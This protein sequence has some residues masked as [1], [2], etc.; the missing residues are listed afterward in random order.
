MTLADRLLIIFAGL[1]LS[2]ITF[3][4]TGA[5]FLTILFGL[6]CWI[7]YRISPSED[8]KFILSV[9]IA[10]FLLRLAIAAGMHATSYL[11]GYGG[12][13][14]GDDLL[15]TVRSWA[16][17]FQW[18]GEPYS[19]VQHLTGISEH[20]VNPF[21]FLLALFYKIFGFHP[22]AVKLISCM[23][24]AFIGWI[25]Y[26]LASELFNR[27]AGRIAM[28]AVA[29]YPSLI[30][31]SIANLKDS[32][33]IL[34]FMTC[35][36]ICIIVL[37]GRTAVWKYA[38]IALSLTILYYFP[39][40][41]HF[42]LAVAGVGLAVFLRLFGYIKTRSR[43]FI[44]FIVIV[45]FLAGSW[46]LLFVNTKPLIK[47][48]HTCEAKQYFIAK[49]DFAGYYFYP[50][51]FLES[52]NEEKVPLGSLLKIAFMNTSYFM[53][54]PFP[55]QFTSRERA[56]AIP[57]MILW[58]IALFLAIFGFYRLACDKAR[59]AVL[60]AAI[61]II[62]VLVHAMAEGN[63]GAAFRHRDLFAPVFIVLA[64]PVL[65]WIFS[66]FKRGFSR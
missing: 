48:L 52:L 29:F 24:G 61:L 49:S 4:F 37:N 27:L 39:N 43:A 5:V 66:T 7:V 38:V 13:T 65:A 22:M 2:V 34:A 50:D 20:G 10:G 25:S 47:L 53:L 45:I 57:Q 35:I 59:A 15:Y 3:F 42:S 8:S 46:Y 23:M 55:W 21:T 18:K 64:S 60:I 31:W 1:F 19:W 44:C 26:L 62:G 17:V 40:R 33:T 32:M 12:A 11:K 16:I 56:V 6:A 63:I 36:Y 41:F 28:L 9:L 30:R 54:T 51:D 14:S 58:H